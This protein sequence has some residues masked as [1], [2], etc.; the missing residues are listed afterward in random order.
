MLRVI[1]LVLSLSFSQQLAPQARVS[2]A[3]SCRHREP[4]SRRSAAPTAAAHAAEDAKEVVVALGCFWLPQS[5]LLAIPGVR[6]VTAGYAISVSDNDGGGS[7][8]PSFND[9]GPF[10]EALRVTYLPDAVDD[11]FFTA[12]LASNPKFRP[13]PAKP[14]T[15]PRYSIPRR[16]SA[17]PR[18]R[19]CAPPPPS[20]TSRS[21]SSPPLSW[22]RIAIRDGPRG[23]WRRWRPRPV[24]PKPV[25]EQK[26]NCVLE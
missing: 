11:A 24:R 2:T 19:R 12:L 22:R 9:I 23:Y 5:N 20:H 26:K 1:A 7:H 6:R 3:S 13:T 25:E 21:T 4:S 14:D 15:V 16:P 10:C 17:R 18:S 8:S